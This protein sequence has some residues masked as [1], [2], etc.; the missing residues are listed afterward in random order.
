MCIHKV[1]NTPVRSNMRNCFKVLP[2]QMEEEKFIMKNSI[3]SSLHFI[4]FVDV[5]L[6]L[7][8]YHFTKNY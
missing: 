8:I 4:I 6:C 3:F 7:I 1:V 5:D 2:A